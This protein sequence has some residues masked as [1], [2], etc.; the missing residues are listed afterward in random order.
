MVFA[1]LYCCRSVV[2]SATCEHINCKF[3]VFEPVMAR[4]RMGHSRHWSCCPAR[5]LSIGPQS[6]AWTSVTTKAGSLG[7]MTEQGQPERALA[8][9]LGGSMRQRG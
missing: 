8:H 7:K 6:L 3:Y 5:A 9:S 1:E 2:S 4:M